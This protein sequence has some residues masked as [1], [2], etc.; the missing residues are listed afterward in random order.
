MHKETKF[1]KLVFRAFAKCTINFVE[2]YRKTR[3]RTWFVIKLNGMEL[4]FSFF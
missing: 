3:L 4:D 1:V 2:T